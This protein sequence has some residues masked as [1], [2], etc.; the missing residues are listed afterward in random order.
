[1]ICFKHELIDKRLRELNIDTP[2]FGQKIG[3]K[4]SHAYA[5][6]AGKCNT[7]LSRLHTISKLLKIDLGDLLNVGGENANN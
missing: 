1:M 5:I 4:R 7:Q 3:L 6:R 2:T